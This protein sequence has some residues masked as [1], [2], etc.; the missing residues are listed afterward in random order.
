M[1]KCPLNPQKK[2]CAGSFHIFGHRQGV[3]V[4]A[5]KLLWVYQTELK[6]VRVLTVLTTINR[7]TALKTADGWTALKTVDLLTALKIVERP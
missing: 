3:W 2:F 6:I 5:T 4:C 1:Q 7:L